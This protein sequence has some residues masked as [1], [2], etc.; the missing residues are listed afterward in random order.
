MTKA[1]TQGIEMTPK[2]KAAVALLLEK[3]PNLDGKSIIIKDGK[4]TIK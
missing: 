2:L 1:T 3:L 4:I